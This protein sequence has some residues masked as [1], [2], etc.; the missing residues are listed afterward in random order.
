MRLAPL[1]HALPLTKQNREGER[2]GRRGGET[3]AKSNTRPSHRAAPHTGS[4]S[5][6][7]G[8]RQR[9]VGRR[10]GGLGRR[11]SRGQRRRGRKG[12]KAAAGRREGERAVAGG[13][14]VEG[15]V[16]EW[17][18]GVLLL[19]GWDWGGGRGCLKIATGDC[20]K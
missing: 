1:G 12:G 9:G 11:R 18:E 13:R 7:N 14:R 4:R 5:C 17:G 8:R 16:R 2:R 15:R 10:D 6:G 20:C 19:A 3:A